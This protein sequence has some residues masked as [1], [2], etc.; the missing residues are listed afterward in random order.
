MSD[1][2]KNTLEI[3]VATVLKEFDASAHRTPGSGCILGGSAGDVANKYF[4]IEC[5]MRHTKENIFMQW[6]QEWLH[7]LNQLPMKTTK[8]PLLITENKYGEKFVILK[9]EDFFS[10]AK[11]VYNDN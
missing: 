5:K 8:T 6:K 10:I 2:K 11:K 3:W 9:A 4:F 1:G 7:L